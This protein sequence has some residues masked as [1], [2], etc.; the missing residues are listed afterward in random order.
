[1]RNGYF[2][3][4]AP[5]RAA[6]KRTPAR[7]QIFVAAVDYGSQRGGPY[8]VTEDAG[9]AGGRRGRASS[10]SGARRERHPVATV[11]IVGAWLELTPSERIALVGLAALWRGSPL[12]VTID[13]L[14]E[15][16]GT[17]HGSMQ[18]SLASF[19]RRRLIAVAPRHPNESRTVTLDP[20]AVG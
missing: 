12:R 13:G 2:A 8:A 16:T 18:R 5:T 10:S 11:R 20:A 3:R 9:R 7:R 15:A 1:L 14:V 19:E 17:S 4:P 6:S